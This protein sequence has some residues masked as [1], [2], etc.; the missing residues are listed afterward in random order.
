VML[1]LQALNDR[2]RYGVPRF[3]SLVGSIALL[4]GS[5][6]SLS[7]A[8][9]SIMP[10]VLCSVP[11]AQHGFCIT[12]QYRDDGATTAEPPPARQGARGPSRA[13]GFTGAEC[14]LL[15]SPQLR[16]AQSFDECMSRICSSGL[17]ASADGGSGGLQTPSGTERCLARV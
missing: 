16:V 4:S 15:V 7:N 17:M 14:Q 8:H 12:H 10:P 6:F 1:L 13:A 11:C 2:S 3:V 9:T 5:I